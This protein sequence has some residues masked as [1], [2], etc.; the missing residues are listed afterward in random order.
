M[1]PELCRYPAGRCVA[2][3]EWVVVRLSSVPFPGGKT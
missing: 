1:L 3:Y 2:G